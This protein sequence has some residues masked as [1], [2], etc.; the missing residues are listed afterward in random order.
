[1]NLIIRFFFGI[2]MIALAHMVNGQS[3]K[4]IHTV[5]GSFTPPPKEVV[6][7]NQE[8]RNPS[9]EKNCMDTTCG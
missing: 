5:H 9:R 1:M 2:A 4:P 8:S 3:V 6:L 7:Q